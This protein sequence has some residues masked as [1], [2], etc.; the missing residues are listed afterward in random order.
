MSVPLGE[1]RTFTMTPESGYA[2][3]TLTVDGRTFEYGGD[4]YTLFDIKAD[5]S[6]HAAFKKVG[7]SD[8]DPGP[9]P[10]DPDDPNGP[11]DPGTDPDPDDPNDPGTDPK[12]V[13][14]FFAI[15]VTAVGHGTV[16]DLGGASSSSVKVAKGASKTFSFLPEPGYEIGSVMVDGGEVAVMS[17]Y[18]FADVRS[19]HTLEVT[20]KAQ[21]APVPNGPGQAISRF[22]QTGDAPLVLAAFAISLAAIA[23]GIAAAIAWRRSPRRERTVRR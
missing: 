7:G 14:E 15:E 19:N 11:D 6:I 13:D 17:H 1:S 21:A 22:A 3:D 16:S 8:P 10:V 5:A 12:P 23:A 2:L 18:T 4:A 9:D 20:F